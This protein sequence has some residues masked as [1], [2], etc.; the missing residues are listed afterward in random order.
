MC[1]A[2]L[3]T[4]ISIYIGV[5][6]THLDLLYRQHQTALQWLLTSPDLLNPM[7]PSCQ[8]VLLDIEKSWL[9][10]TELDAAI[11]SLNLEKLPRRIGLYAENL[12]AVWLRQK[13]WLLDRNIQLFEGRVTLGELDFL[14]QT[15]RGLQHWEL[16]TKFF[17]GVR[18]GP[19]LSFVGPNLADSLQAKWQKILHQQLALSRHAAYLDYARQHHL[20]EQIEARALI[21]GWLFYPLS[22]Q[23]IGQKTEP[24]KTGP[25]F[26]LNP[27][28]GRGWWGTISQVMAIAKA[29]WFLVPRHRWLARVQVT[30]FEAEQ[31][32]E[33]NDLK[34]ALESALQKQ[35]GPILL[36][37]VEVDAAGGWT[38]QARFFVVPDTWPAAAADYAQSIKSDGMC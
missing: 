25:E 19:T 9:D 14:V 12:L 31:V 13:T 29:S 35:G 36:A 27:T 8:D 1:V 2:I 20:P 32:I 7:H 22:E 30:D 5:A 34:L 15:P 24:Q 26:L 37:Q 28:H 23:E 16:A 3:F 18:S 38:E 11:M 10:E 6:I 21:K 4:T 33:L 17:L